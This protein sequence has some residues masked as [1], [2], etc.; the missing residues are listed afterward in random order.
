METGRLVVVALAEGL[1]FAG[2]SRT[3]LN[4]VD[5]LV[6]VTERFSFKGLVDLAPVRDTVLLISPSTFF[7]ETAGVLKFLP[8]VVV[9]R[10][11]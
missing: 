4:F 7:L 9:R 6:F 8:G 10:T 2:V 3:F 1:T 11:F 5:G